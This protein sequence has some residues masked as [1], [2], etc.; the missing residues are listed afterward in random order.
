MALFLGAGAVEVEQAGE[1]LLAEGCGPEEAVLVAVLG[2]RGF[3]EE[4]GCGAGGE[5]TPAI[6]LQHRKIEFVV[7]FTEADNIGVL[8]LGIVDEPPRF[9]RRLFCLSYAAMAG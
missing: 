7:Q 5:V 4:F 2:F 3:C 8:V 9:C 6:G 1:D